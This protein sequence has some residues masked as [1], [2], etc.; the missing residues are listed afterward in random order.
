MLGKGG[1]CRRSGPYATRPAR[2]SSPNNL[3]TGLSTST[4]QGEELP[5]GKAEE[6]VIGLPEPIEEL[7]RTG[8]LGG[9]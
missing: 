4:C 1:P 9:L 3:S 6:I 8:A 7:I 2:Y 5:Q